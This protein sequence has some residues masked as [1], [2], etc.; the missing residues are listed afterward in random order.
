MLESDQTVLMSR[1]IVWVLAVSLLAGAAQAYIRNQLR[2][3]VPYF[4]ADAANVAFLVDPET[5]PGMRNREGDPIISSDS[6]PTA[7]IAAAMER[8]SDIPGSALRFAPPLPAED[9]VTRIDDLNLVSFADDSFNRA[10]VGGAIAVTRLNSDSG[11][12][13]TDTDILFNPGLPFSTT[14]APGTFDIEGTLTHELGHAIG[15]D[16]AG[17][18][19]STMFATAVRG[20]RRL[21]TLTADDRAFVREVYPAT[22]ADS[23]GILSGVVRTSVGTP[24]SGALVS[25][26][27]VDRNIVVGVI[28]EGSGEY[29]FGS[30]PPGEYVL[31]L[32]PLDGPARI[33][34]LSFSRAGAFQAFRTAVLGGPRTPTRIAVSAGDEAVQDLTIED[35][36]AAFNIIG[37]AITP[38]KGDPLTRAG[39]VVEPG[40][41]YSL[42]MHGEGLDAPELS[43]ASL[44]VLGTG[45][46]IVSDSFARD[47]LDLGG[48][49]PFSML[50]FDIFVSPQAPA[51]TLSVGVATAT[52]AALLTAGIEV[53]PAAPP[54]AFSRD[55]VV[56]AASFVGGAVAPGQIVS[57]FGE[58]LGPAVA[59]LGRFDTVSGG[60]RTELN[61]TAVFFQQTPA[62]LF[63]AGPGQI[64]LQ[65]PD[66]VQTGVPAFVRIVREGV[67]S[68]PALVPV[69]DRAPGVFTL[70]GVAAAALNEDGILNS[71]TAPAA[72]GSAVTIFATGPGSTTPQVAAG[73]PAPAD[74]LSVASGVSVFVDDQPA[75]VLFAGLAPGFV[76]LLQ[77]NLRV[78]QTAQP[79]HSRPLRLRIG[80]TQAA[81]ATLAIQ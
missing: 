7:A 49:E 38:E 70:D 43:E 68:A 30:L 17:P 9:G 64:N 39:V 55:S 3:G 73:R 13:F 57:I 36:A 26:V 77:V 48:E 19:T 6:S 42:Q 44:L 4:V 75:E 52:D 33:N 15:M 63:Y 11:G 41:T 18:V 34:Q 69:Q 59:A 71:P 24:V 62:P 27:E 22:G 28:S 61:E 20:S 60:L 65:V 23:M 10:I 54:P 72:R 1:R 46:S 37:L 53:Q 67:A 14:Q 2:P 80:D 76:G 29:R 21:R 56:N 8:W 12:A 47:T 31:T 5:A 66:T 51:G 78:P 74:P 81:T 16:H 40:R 58:N 25:A 50:R 32:D 79:G 45:V 35:G